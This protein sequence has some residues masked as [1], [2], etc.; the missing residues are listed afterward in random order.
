MGNKQNGYGESITGTGMAPG[1]FAQVFRPDERLH[2]DILEA[3]ADHE[4]L[5]SDEINV[6]IRNGMVTL[7]GYVPDGWMRNFAEDLVRPI[8]GV[9][10]IDNDIQTQK[11]DFTDLRAS[12]PND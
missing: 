3:F 4:E 5:E 1:V 10:H 2:Q 7:S 6:E 11:R 9:K 8:V 12:L